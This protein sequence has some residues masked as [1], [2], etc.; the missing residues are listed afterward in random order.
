MQLAGEERAGWVSV[1]EVESA[2]SMWQ[3]VRCPVAI[4]G[5]VWSSE[6]REL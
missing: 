1:G 5:W 3:P 2:M 4:V 6:E